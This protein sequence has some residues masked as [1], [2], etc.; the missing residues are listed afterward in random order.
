VLR[1][2]FILKSI[3]DNFKNLQWVLCRKNDYVVLLVMSLPKI[4]I[5]ENSSLTQGGDDCTTF[6]LPPITYLASGHLG[7]FIH[8]L[9]IVNEK[10]RITGRKGIIYMTDSIE[11]FRW[12]LVRTYEDIKPIILKQH[13]IYDLRIHDGCSCDINLSIWRFNINFNS[14]HTIFKYHYD[15]SWSDTPWFCTQGMTKY[16]NTVFISTSSMRFLEQFNYT[17]LIIIFGPDIRFLTSEKSNYDHFVASTGIEIPLV[18]APSFTE[19][20]EA[21]QGCALFVS[22]PSA[23]LAIADALHKKRL[24]LL[25]P[26]TPDGY[27]AAS[28]NP[29][30]ITP[31]SNLNLIHIKN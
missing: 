3:I 6:E 19:M 25:D 12:G 20:V 1:Y 30:F 14:W 13:Y 10:Y 2:F 15:V 28:T 8:Q 16:K 9:S 21:I 11:H 23:P 29:S 17:K 26:C 7:D 24:A 18:L 22:T 31:K 5:V 27:I 4:P